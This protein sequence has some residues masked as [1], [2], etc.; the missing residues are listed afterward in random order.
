LVA[1]NIRCGVVGL[2]AVEVALLDDAALVQHQRRVNVCVA[3]Q[4][5]RPG[6][7]RL[8]RADL[9][10][11]EVAPRLGQRPYRATGRQRPR[12]EQ[13]ARVLERPDLLRPALPVADVDAVLGR[14]REA[15]HQPGGV[16]RRRRRLGLG[17]GT[18]SGQGQRGSGDEAMESVHRAHQ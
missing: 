6:L 11:V 13:F 16:E 8:G 1:E 3:G 9:Q 15:Q 18:Q 10:P 7:R 2:H 5:L 4:H 14:R 12:R 17:P